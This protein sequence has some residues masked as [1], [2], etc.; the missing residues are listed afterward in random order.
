MA[1]ASEE[2]PWQDVFLS[3]ESVLSEVETE[4]INPN[5]SYHQAALLLNRLETS[6]YILTS[7]NAEVTLQ[8]NSDRRDNH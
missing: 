4:K 2:A 1:A 6:V 7:L 8:G 3:M 5:L